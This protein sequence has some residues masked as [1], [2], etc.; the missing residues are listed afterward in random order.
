MSIFERGEEIDPENII[1]EDL[2][3]NDMTFFKFAPFT[4]VD[5]ERSFSVYNLLKFIIYNFKILKKL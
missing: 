3:P 2:S 5:V 1:P 4:S